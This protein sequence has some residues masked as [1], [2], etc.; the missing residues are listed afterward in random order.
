MST[1][2]VQSVPRIAST[3]DN[4][5]MRKL[6][7]GAAVIASSLLQGCSPTLNWRDVRVENTPLVALFPCKSDTG[8]RV[9]PIGTLNVTISMSG[10]TAGDAIFTVA[11]ADV[12]DVAHVAAALAQWKVATLGA[13]RAQSASELPLHIK[14]ASPM[15]PSIAVRANGWRPDGSAVAAQAVWFA[16]GSRIFQAVIYANAVSPAEAETYFSGLRLD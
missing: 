5:L 11:H 12:A 10:C 8:S 2:R 1:C 7:F 15:P 9:I 13:M 4:C 3:V 16:K 6:I 14:G